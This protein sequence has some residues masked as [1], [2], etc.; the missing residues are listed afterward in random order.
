MKKISLFVVA[1]LSIIFLTACK[2]D[3]SDNQITNIEKVEQ[4]I[5][6]IPSCITT[7]NTSQ[8]KQKVRA[9]GED[10]SVYN[11]YDGVTENIVAVK[12]WKQYILEVIRLIE[13]VNGLTSDGRYDNSETGESIVWQPSDNADYDRMAE[14][15][16]DG[17]LGFQAYLTFNDQAAKG[18]IIWDFSIAEDDENPDNKS[19]VEITFDGISEP[20]SLEIKVLNMNSLN[21]ADEPER[22]WVKITRDTNRKV[23]LW[24]NYAFLELNLSDNDSGEERNYVFAVTGYD[25]GAT[26]EISNKAVM[27]LAL[28]LST[29]DSLTNMWEEDS[30][31]EMFYDVIRDNLTNPI[32]TILKIAE[33]IPN[34]VTQQ[35]IT[36][37]QILVSLEYFKDNSS[38]SSEIDSLLFVLDLVNPAYFHSNGFI[39]T[40]DGENGTLTQIPE[41]FDDF[42]LSTVKADV[43]TP[44]E[45]SELVIEF[46]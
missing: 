10:D 35:T 42:D 45:L 5:V 16:Q 7:S 2:D 28:P 6:D 22:A 36:N 38:S 40:F 41:G 13:T 18:L 33:V 29:R 11:V 34:D 15:Y 25:E 31:G 19:K 21:D 8:S 17:E 37:E 23:N 46:L 14:L 30:I 26:G 4:S 24:G 1:A 3:K 32:L 43:K 9:E 27:N 44:L 12:E 39:G 20:K